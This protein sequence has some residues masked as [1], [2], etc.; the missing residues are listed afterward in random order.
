MGSARAGAARLPAVVVPALR[1][2][3]CADGLAVSGGALRCPRRHTFDIAR[4]GYVNLLHAKV[5]AGTAD[6]AEMVA[7]RAAFLAAG[8]YA[9]LA[10]LLAARAAELADSGLVVDAGAGT[11]YHLA[12]VLDALPAAAGI[13]LD[14]SAVALRRAAGAHPRIGAAVW[15]LWREWP[16]GTGVAD[17]VLN[18]FAPRN[19]TEFHR[20]L[21]PG[22]ALLVVS[23]GPGHLAE[24]AGTL[25][26]LAV[27]RDKEERLDAG[28]AGSFTLVD[29]ANR[30][31]ALTLTVDEARA[32]VR[33]GPNAHHLDRDG[34]ADRLAALAGPVA[35][36]AS[37]VLSTYRPR[38][39]RA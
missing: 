27:E 36:T 12:R 14:V 19:A 22:G 20:V 3:V 1:C 38:K 34:L 37:F 9:P 26:L 7:A 29:R 28:L 15:N 39:A 30:E 5:P 21:R 2:S 17:L 13:A 23:P 16:I 6:T 31:L 25:G 4:Q 8:H 10:E 11:G 32:L 33:M 35:V 18:V 24:L